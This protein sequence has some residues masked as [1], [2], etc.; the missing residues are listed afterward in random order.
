VLG[1]PDFRV[2]VIEPY[3][4]LG[5]VDDRLRVALGIDVVGAL[6]RRSIFGTE[7]KDWKS[8][9]LFDG[10]EC[11]VSGDFNLTPAP[12][13]GW[14]MHPEGDT[15]AAPSGHMAPGGYFFDAVVRQPPLDETK[16]D[17]ADNAEEFGP[18]NEADLAYFRTKAEWFAER[19]HCGALLVIPGTAFGD[20]ALVPAPWMKHP[21]GIRD[22]T[23]W[24]ISTKTRGTLSGGS[25]KQCEYALQTSAP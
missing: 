14:Y 9:R 19:G 15:S 5:E 24:Y 13:G 12:D 8:F 23:E 25:S 4:M 17:P 1:E 3:Q 2:R 21:K 6:P 10:T 20:I 22:I 16:L 18:L 7:S 11:L